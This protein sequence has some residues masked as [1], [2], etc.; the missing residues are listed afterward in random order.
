MNEIL[1]PAGTI[2]SFYAAIANGANAIYLGLDKF[3][4]RAYANNFTISTLKELTDF[5]HLRNV[6][7]YLTIKT[8]FY[9][10]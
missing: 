10:Y 9:D 1:S 2:E 8:N 6:K 3:N 7:I 4:A 5:A